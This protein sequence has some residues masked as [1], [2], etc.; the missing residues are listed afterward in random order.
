MIASLPKN[1]AKLTAFILVFVT[2]SVCAQNIDIHILR[3]L[4]TP[5]RLPS[6]K[7]FQFVSNSAAVLEIGVPAG[8]VTT[9]LINHD[10]QTVRKACVAI[11][12][13]A[14]CSGIT[15]AVKYSVNRDRPFITYPD[16]AKKSA[17]G[18]PSFP[19]GHTS[20]A[21]VLATSLT[22]SYPKWYI[23]VPAYTWAC[24]VAY[25]R[26]DLGVHYPSDVLAG[27]LIGTGSAWLTHY[28]NK[29]LIIKSKKKPVS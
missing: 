8:I 14:I 4:N 13:A 2:G 10:D 16:I 21:F 17:A 1:S 3:Y 15:L 5:A 29:K 28:I 6:D 27:A 26:M 9:G 22:L 23:I 19:S 7:F 20:G 18:S 25:S 11:A 24:T 12:A